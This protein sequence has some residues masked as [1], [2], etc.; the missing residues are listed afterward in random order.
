MI[1]SVWNAISSFGAGIK[2]NI[3]TYL[4]ITG[5]IVIVIVVLYVLVGMKSEEARGVVSGAR[6]E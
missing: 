3:V 1:S 4:A 6:K 5:G 2:N